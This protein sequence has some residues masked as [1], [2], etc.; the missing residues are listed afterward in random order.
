MT[1][2]HP[3]IRHLEMPGSMKQL[4]L[5]ENGYPVLYFSGE[6]DGK[7][8]LRVIDPRK[9]AKCVNENLCW[10]CGR[11]LGR[12]K[13]FVI[14]PMCA[15]TRTTAEPPSHYECAIYAVKACPFLTRPKARRRESGMPEDKFVPGVCIERNPGVSAVWIVASVGRGYTPFR[16]PAGGFLLRVGTPL[17][18]E[19]WAEGRQATYTEVAESLESG[20]P[21]LFEQCEKDQDSEQS[22]LELVKYCANMLPFLRDL[23]GREARKA[24]DHDMNELVMLAVRA[25]ER[26]WFATHP[27]EAE[28]I[29]SARPGE[30]PPDVKPTHVRVRKLDPA[31]DKRSREFGVLVNG[32]FQPAGV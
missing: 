11:R 14:G 15:V 29:R 13:A 2:L 9:R 28:Y 30:Y 8:D 3:T 21:A 26:S 32:Q 4:P 18:V 19:W 12:L 6:V 22:R 31:A 7:P 20:L 16:A 10:L 1:E 17:R 23:P 5:T 24:E 25:D 27:D